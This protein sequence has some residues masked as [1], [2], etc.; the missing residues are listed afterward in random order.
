MGMD[1]GRL[2]KRETQ[3]NVIAY[4]LIVV[5]IATIGLLVF[6]VLAG[7]QIPESWLLRDQIFR[8]LAVGLLLMV[9]LYL[10]DQHRRLRAELVEAHTELE[11]AH[12]DIAASCDRLA[13][14]HRA[15]EIMTAFAH[16][17]GLRLVL[18]E[19][20][21][22]FAVDAAA[23]VGDDIAITTADGVDAAEAQSAV[24][25]AAVQAVTAGKPL[26]VALSDTGSIAIAVPLRVRGRLKSVAA[27]W[28]REQA[29]TDDEL[30]GLGLVARVIELGMENRI[31][32]AEVQSQLSGT[33]RAMV[34]LVEHRR[35]DYTTH[36][37]HVSDYA[38]E[39]GRALGIR[40]EEILQ[41]RLAAMLHDVGMLEVP[42][43]ILDAPRS[44]TDQETAEVRKHPQNGADLA[45]MANFGR[46]VQEGI[47][48]HHERLDG[49]GYPRGL[50]GEAIPLVARILAVCD[51][52]VAMTSS[53][54]HRQ[55]STPMAA[56]SRLRAG[57]GRAY[58]PRVVREFIRTQVT[59]VSD[60][61]AAPEPVDEQADLQLVASHA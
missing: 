32:L 60:G 45:K 3:L 14:S 51:S 35:P 31:L 13:F 8:I 18:A 22:H 27:L 36:S 33:L 59:V 52:Y 26:S 4:G 12:R 44:L 9:I 17:D 48:Y 11:A 24:L 39:V 25:A 34:D 50:V 53:R 10:A 47:L 54:P 41:V 37:A 20:V 19:S 58:D 23:V 2:L 30:E 21:Q 7:I 55:Q 1:I 38:V 28:R 49:S 16:E 6:M 15:A 46:T 40:E 5:L 61:G 56:L 43:S 29:F 57:A 42:E